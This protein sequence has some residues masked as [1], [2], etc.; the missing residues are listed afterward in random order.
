M[1]LQSKIG[2]A[3]LS[4]PPPDGSRR[5]FFVTLGIG[6][7]IGI[8]LSVIVTV[9][10][11]NLGFFD[12][13]YVC[14]PATSIETCPPD[15][16]LAQPSPTYTLTPTDAAK[17]LELTP[18]PTFTETPDIGATATAACGVFESQFPGTPCPDSSSP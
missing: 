1:T 17:S 5:S 9:I 14:P 3:P 16:V 8:L 11:F 7:L 4:E 6:I 2:T 15:E 13:F 18:S 10:L 12:H